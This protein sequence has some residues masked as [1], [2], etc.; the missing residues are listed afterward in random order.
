MLIEI[1][2]LDIYENEGYIFIFPMSKLSSYGHFEELPSIKINYKTTSTDVG[3]LILKA[4]KKVRNYIFK[5][6]PFTEEEILK[7]IGA[8]KWVTFINKSCHCSVYQWKNS[9]KI[10]ISPGYRSASG[11]EY[12]DELEANL[13]DP[14]DIGEKVLKA[15]QTYEPKY[16]TKKKKK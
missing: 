12:G 4:S 8:K 15:L 2:S 14:Q 3:K 7:D 10:I 1:F 5:E 6:N 16:P 13:D 11:F 9:D